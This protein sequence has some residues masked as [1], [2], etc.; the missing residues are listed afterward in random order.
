VLIADCP[1]ARPGEPSVVSGLWPRHS[2][3]RSTA[4]IGAR[5]PRTPRSRRRRR[6][7]RREPPHDMA[8]APV[9]TRTRRCCGRL[10]PHTHADDAAIAQRELRKPIQLPPVE[11]W[12]ILRINHATIIAPP[13]R[14][15]GRAPRC[16][17]ARQAAG[18][19]RSR[20][21]LGEMFRDCEP[22]ERERS[23]ILLVAREVSREQA[24]LAPQLRCFPAVALKSVGQRRKV[25]RHLGRTP[26]GFRPPRCRG[27]SPSSPTVDLTR[28]VSKPLYPKVLVCVKPSSR[29]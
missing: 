10:A 4:P 7:T 5:R 21:S 28:P 3:P 24:P 16:R 17:F 26:L 12:R 8:R 20:Y 27:V 14:P 15:R 18:S 9:A 6:A 22:G 11:R 1:S 13:E 2:Q 29:E 23:A 25:L 19:G